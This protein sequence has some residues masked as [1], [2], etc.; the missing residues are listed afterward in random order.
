[1]I[2]DFC[3]F[4]EGRDLLF[5]H[6]LPQSSCAQQTERIGSDPICCIYLFTYLFIALC[7]QLGACRLDTADRKEKTASSKIGVR[8]RTNAQAWPPQGRRLPLHPR[9]VVLKEVVVPLS[10]HRH[11]CSI[12]CVFVVL[13]PPPGVRCMFRIRMR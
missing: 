4:T 5:A 8:K 1:M 10:G 6:Y 2:S 13:S 7:I 11:W 3:G 12:F 9:L